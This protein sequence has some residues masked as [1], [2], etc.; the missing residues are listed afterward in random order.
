VILV[1]GGTG[2][3][4]KHLLQRLSGEGRSV[5][6]LVRHSPKP[7]TLPPGVERAEGDLASGTGLKAALDGVDTVLHLAGA[8]KVLR[9]E[10]Y[11]PG[12]AGATGQLVRAMAG[13]GLRLVHVS[14][15]AAA[16][17]AQNGRPV[18]EDDEPHPVSHYGRSKLEAER[19]VR[20]L[21]PE[22]TIVRPPVV[23]GPG[24]TDVF[25]LLKSV[26]QGLSIEVDGGRGEFSAIYVHDL[27]DGILAVAAADQSKGRTYYLTHFEAST[28]RQ[29]GQLAARIMDKRPRAL[30]V[31]WS[32]AYAAAACA[33]LWARLRGKPGIVSRDKLREGRFPSWTCNGALAAREI[34]FTA[35]TTLEVGLTRTLAW[36]KEAGWLTY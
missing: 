22:A 26:A 36:Y 27:V 34:G 13:R 8:T 9:P 5:R 7:R 25:Q 19:I 28:W 11:Y 14:S 35:S 2:F 17:P 33:E 20:Q 32:A 3:I 23:Y 1:T 15:L 21:A 30:S 29:L 18:T 24:D 10:E 31:P 16:G 6:A 4:G 12:N